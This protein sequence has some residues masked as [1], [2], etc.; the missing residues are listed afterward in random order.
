MNI[1]ATST[2]FYSPPNFSIAVH[3][4]FRA[5][6]MLAYIYTYASTHTCIL[7]SIIKVT[8]S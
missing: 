2:S 3:T 6:Y 4:Q 5:G 1:H 8:H 7:N